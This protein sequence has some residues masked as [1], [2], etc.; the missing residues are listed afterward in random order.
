MLVALVLILAHLS[1]Q[2]QS[3]L[4]NGIQP[5]SRS[6]DVLALGD[7][8]PP[9]SRAAKYCSSDLSN[10]GFVVWSSVSLLRDED[11]L[12]RRYRTADGATSIDRQTAA[13]FD[14]AAY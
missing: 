1:P 8:D 14:L 4:A 13:A 6:R 7:R 12:A 9:D 2:K 11:C 5:A 3:P 10:R